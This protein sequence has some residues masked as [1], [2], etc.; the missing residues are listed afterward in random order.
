MLAMLYPP[1]LPFVSVGELL[2]MLFPDGINELPHLS[3]PDF[4]ANVLK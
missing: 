3:S 1:R 4:Q 2:E